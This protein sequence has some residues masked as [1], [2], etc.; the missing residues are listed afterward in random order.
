MAKGDDMAA[1]RNPQPPPGGWNWEGT[2]VGNM[3]GGWSEGLGQGGN[4][5]SMQT[6]GNMGRPQPPFAMGNNPWQTFLNAKNWGQQQ[7]NIGYGGMGG[8]GISPTER[9]NNGQGYPGIP[10]PG[11]GGSG[12]GPSM[13]TMGNMFNRNRGQRPQ[14][15]RLLWLKVI[16]LALLLLLKVRE[17]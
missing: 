10:I 8:G 16:L 13:G 17:L 12:I 1:A 11:Q 7:G 6:G 5:G 15:Q 14:Y 2:P 4:T 9:G 3:R